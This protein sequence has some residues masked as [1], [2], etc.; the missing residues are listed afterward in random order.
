MTIRIR[1]IV[2]STKRRFSFPPVLKMHSRVSFPRAHV[3]LAEPYNYNISYPFVPL[4]SLPR[5]TRPHVPQDEQRLL[6]SIDIFQ[7]LPAWYL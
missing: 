4:L 7:L 5:L 2:D 6:R 3:P 1:T